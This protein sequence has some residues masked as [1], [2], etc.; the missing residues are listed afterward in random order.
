MGK[1]RLFYG[2]VN[3]AIFFLMTMVFWGPHFGFGVFFKSLAE[4]FAWSRAQIS[5]AMTINLMI[6][7]LLG[8]WVGGLSILSQL[9]V[10][11]S[12]EEGS[13]RAKGTSARKH[14][15]AVEICPGASATLQDADSG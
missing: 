15:P 3:V 2:W 13:E 5:A 4:Q 8:F 6:G 1:P 7:G 11:S 9:G 12:V 10:L 14:G